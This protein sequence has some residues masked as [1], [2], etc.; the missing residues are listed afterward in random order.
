MLELLHDWQTLVGALLGGV[1]ALGAALVVALRTDRRQDLASAML[2]VSTLVSVRA[3]HVSLKE[4]KEQEEV[5][6]EHEA[7]WMLEKLVWMHPPITS[8]FEASTARI[9]PL[10]VSMAAHLDLFLT[11]YRD[12][13]NRIDRVRDLEPEFKQG[14]PSQEAVE[15]MQAEARAVQRSFTGA[16]K[17]AQCAE[18]LITKLV[19]SRARYWYRVRR[20]VGTSGDERACANLLKGDSA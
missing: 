10:D 3:G 17:H 2:V 7:V 16:A 5:P 12:V 4:L 1:F 6:D 14:T 19:L 13:V 18:K 20:W 15:R 9:Y 11:M 8:G